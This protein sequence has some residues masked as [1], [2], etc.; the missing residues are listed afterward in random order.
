M[1]SQVAAILRYLLRTL[2]TPFGDQLRALLKSA[3]CGCSRHARATTMRTRRESFGNARTGKGAT[4]HRERPAIL[5]LEPDRNP[6]P[7]RS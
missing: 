6:H 1:R 7:N 3:R 2:Q 4:C 5:S